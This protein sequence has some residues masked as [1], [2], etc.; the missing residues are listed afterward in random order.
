MENCFIL[1]YIDILNEMM[2]ID[3]DDQQETNCL[4]FMSVEGVIETYNCE[5]G[6]Y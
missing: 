2:D 1:H 4:P 6:D 3:D 5:I